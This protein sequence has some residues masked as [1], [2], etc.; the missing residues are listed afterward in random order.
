M[1]SSKAETFSGQTPSCYCW[2]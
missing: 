1:K 2:C